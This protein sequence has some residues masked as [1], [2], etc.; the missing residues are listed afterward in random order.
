MWSLNKNQTRR[1]RV[2]KW[3]PGLA[4]GESSERLVKEY[5]LSAIKWVRPEELWSNTGT[6]A[7][8]TI[9]CNRNTP[10]EWHLSCSHT[11]TH[12]HTHTH[13]RKV[14]LM[15]N[16]P[17][18]GYSKD[19]YGAVMNMLKELNKNIPRMNKHTET[20]K[21]EMKTMKKNRIKWKFWNLR[22]NW[23]GYLAYLR[24]HKKKFMNWE[25]RPVEI[26]QA[27]EEK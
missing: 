4:S 19:F 9:L 1:N 21:G 26:I 15:P 17:D 13:K 6:L 2:E 3:L 23:I 25:N 11:H 7:T 14:K 10:A 18:V 16:S 22:I 24:W 5:K 12:T 27:E 20:L 8:T